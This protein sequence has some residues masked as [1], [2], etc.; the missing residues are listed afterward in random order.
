MNY[1]SDRLRRI[2]YD[3]ALALLKSGRN[4]YV[5]CGNGDEIDDRVEIEPDGFGGFMCACL[6]TFCCWHRFATAG[7]TAERALEDARAHLSE[8]HHQ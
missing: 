6:N 4:V 3:R 1:E 2:S 5:V 8:D 7:D